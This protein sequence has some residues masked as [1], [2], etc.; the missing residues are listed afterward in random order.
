LGHGQH[1]G[2]GV[3]ANDFASLADT[4]EC[5]ASK[6]TGPTSHVEHPVTGTDSGFVE[7]DPWPRP[8]KRGN[9]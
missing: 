4:S 5:L 3:E 8:E 9:E 7:H 1:P 6:D 2:I